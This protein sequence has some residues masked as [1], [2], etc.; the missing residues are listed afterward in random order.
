MTARSDDRPGDADPD[1]PDAA[2]VLERIDTLQRGT[3]EIRDA[4]LAR[5]TAIRD[6]SSTK[7]QMYAWMRE[8]LTEYERSSQRSQ[9]RSNI[10]AFC[11]ALFVTA[12]FI[13]CATAIIALLSAG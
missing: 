3:V 6:P 11:G 13:A 7:G 9:L 8:R 12:C 5:I 10:L 4:L 1:A 2:A